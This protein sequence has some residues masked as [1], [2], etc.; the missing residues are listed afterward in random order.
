MFL[1]NCIIFSHKTRF[2]GINFYLN[3]IVS[4]V[5]KKFLVH[6]GITHWNSLPNNI[7]SI[8][9]FT[10]FKCDIFECLSSKYL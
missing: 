4:S 2:C 10:K 1:S 3:Q 8:I 5:H 7:T 9:S 6:Q